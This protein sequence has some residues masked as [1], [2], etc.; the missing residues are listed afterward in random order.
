M[1]WARR[2]RMPKL[3]TSPRRTPQVW[4]PVARAASAPVDAGSRPSSL[5]AAWRAKGSDSTDDPDRLHRCF[6]VVKIRP[7]VS[8]DQPADSAS[9][10][11]M[12]SWPAKYS[13]DSVDG[14]AGAASNPGVPRRWFICSVRRR[15]TSLQSPKF[16][17]TLHS[18][19]SAPSLKR[20]D[21]GGGGVRGTLPRGS[22]NSL[23]Q[24]HAETARRRSIQAEFSPGPAPPAARAAST[25]LSRV[26]QCERPVK[27]WSWSRS[28]GANRNSSIPRSFP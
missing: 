8:G 24:D 4:R 3:S 27:T 18:N 15:R 28:A 12:P 11:F 9:R 5:G 7:G 26:I 17:V 16:S 21:F 10:I 14:A 19:F 23:R 2:R 13:C 25:S 6:P 20:G 22:R 1:V